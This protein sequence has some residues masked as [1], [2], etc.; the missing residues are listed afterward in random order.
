VGRSPHQVVT[1]PLNG[2]CVGTPTRHSIGLWGS[3]EPEYPVEGIR[4]AEEDW[5]Q[6]SGCLAST[7]SSLD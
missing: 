6:I 5:K 1:R 3:L 7:N 4:R 2:S